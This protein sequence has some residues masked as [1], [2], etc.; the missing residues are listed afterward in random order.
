MSRERLEALFRAR[1]HEA[2]RGRATARDGDLRDAQRRRRRAVH[3]ARPGGLPQRAHLPG[4]RDAARVLGLFHFGLRTRGLLFLGPSET[5]GKLEDEFEPVVAEAKVYAKRR[6][7]RLMAHSSLTESRAPP[8]RGRADRAT[9]AEGSGTR[10]LRVAARALYADCV[11]AESSSNRSC[12][13]SAAPR[14]CWRCAAG[15]CPRR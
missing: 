5:L 1:R 8:R 14:S 4:A 7:L 9:F 6:D 11:P 15:A 12:I 2:A 10:G 3:A 13:A